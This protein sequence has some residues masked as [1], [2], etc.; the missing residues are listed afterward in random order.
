MRLSPLNHTD[1][2]IGEP[3]PWPVYDRG[4]KLLLKKGEIVATQ[5]QLRGVIER[6]HLTDDARRGDRAEPPEAVRIG[7][8]RRGSP[9]FDQIRALSAQ[10]G[11]LH[12]ALRAAAPV[13]PPGRFEELTDS[14]RQALRADTDAVLAT[15]QL[16]A[17]NNNFA[18]RHLHVA[19]LCELIAR[20][21][22]LDQEE[23]DGLCCAALSFDIGFAELHDQLD[24]QAQPLDAGQTEMLHRHPDRTVELLRQSG[25]ASPLWLIAVQQ[26]HERIDGSGYP[27]GL[28]GG[29]IGMPARILAI[30]DTY[31]AMIR[32][33]AYRAAFQARQALRDMFIQRGHRIDDDLVNA[34]VK[35]LGIFPPGCFVRLV[36]GELGVVVR[37]TQNAAYPTVRSLI[38]SDGI[39][40]QRPLPRDVRATDTAIVEAVVR[41]RMLSVLDRL[42]ALWAG[43]PE[44]AE[45]PPSEGA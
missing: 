7:S 1:I 15:L 8:G 31:S 24:R 18:E 35:E 43:G 38:S 42:P 41:E 19:V 3:L 17:G 12:S 36:N 37:R 9:V 26:H 34:F 44:A 27:D 5:T 30:A 28:R 14:L 40:L 29:Q 2:R 23:R 33:R 10:L 6:G 25:V 11:G 16:D 13:V 32:P 22:G 21:I 4:G 20:A 45:S 39:V